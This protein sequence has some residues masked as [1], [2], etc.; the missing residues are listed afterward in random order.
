M[1][2]VTCLIYAFLHAVRGNWRNAVF[3]KCGDCPYG[4]KTPCGGFLLAADADGRPLL[5]HTGVIRVMSG[6]TPEESECSAALNR[7]QIKTLY[8]SWLEWNTV[9]ANECKLF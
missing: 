2:N 3:V 6:I 7:E 4:E 1:K 8:A 5:L 9:S